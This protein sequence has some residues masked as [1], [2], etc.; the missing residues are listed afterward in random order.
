MTSVSCLACGEDRLLTLH[1]TVA[2]VAIPAV[3]QAGPAVTH[4]EDRLPLSPQQG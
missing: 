2:E 4:G 3:V 1:R